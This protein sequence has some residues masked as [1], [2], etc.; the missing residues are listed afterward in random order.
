MTVTIGSNISALQAQRRLFESSQEASSVFERLSSGQRINRASD[1]A[2][3]LAISDSLNANRRVFNQGV[4]NFNDGLSLL[5]IA[6]GVVEQL[7]GLVTRLAELAEQAANGILGSQQRQS[8]N[9]EAQ[10]LSDEFFRIIRSSEFNGS[11]LFD[12]TLG[13]LRLQGGFGLNGGIASS[14]GGALGT[15][16]FTYNSQFFDSLSD[17]STVRD[18]ASADI[19]GDGH[20]DIVEVGDQSIGLGRQ[21]TV[22]LGNG[23]GTFQEGVSMSSIMS[24]IYDVHLEDIN[25]DG[26]LDLIT[27]GKRPAVGAGLVV[28]LGN[29]D[30]TFSD[31]TLIT[32]SLGNI[33]NLSFGDVNGDGILDILANGTRLDNAGAASGVYLG[34]GSGSFQEFVTY[35]YS[36]TLSTDGHLYDLNNDGYLDLIS[37]SD[38]GAS[39]ISVQLGDGHGS[40]GTQTTY[41]AHGTVT[42]ALAIADLNGDGV[43]DLV[44]AGAS[45]GGSLQVRFGDGN[46]G[47]GS[48]AQYSF[49]GNTLYSV[50]IA[51]LNGD[52]ILDLVAGGQNSTGGGEDV[53]VYLGRGDGTFENE[54]LAS[55]SS[56]RLANTLALSDFNEDGVLDLVFGGELTTSSGGIQTALAQTVEGISPLLEFSLNSV[57]D[58]LQALSQFRNRLEIL[59]KQRGAIGAFQSR[60]GTGIRILEASSENYASAESRIRDADIASESARLVQVTILQQAAAAVLSQA[61]LQPQLATTLL[62][63]I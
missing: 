13:T 6:D 17:P 53:A 41:S 19:N 22:R 31:A 52:G 9:E 56:I 62:R 4:R 11:N 33:R 37:T 21:I 27:A 47:F 10:A 58:A 23:D 12:G 61:N 40:F 2:A 57:A 15:G 20:A 45:G 39:Y 59:S 18:I 8:L 55:G 30:G 34:N 63:D 43:F 28:Q 50:Q 46:G 29:G 16:N 26:Q 38:N 54:S 48:A 51:D 1:D 49:S 44:A 42:N 7:S 25:G 14:L 36:G 3:G 60:L 35:L 32:N 24:D 5:N